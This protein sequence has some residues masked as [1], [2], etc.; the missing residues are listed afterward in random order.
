MNAEGPRVVFFDATSF[1][2]ASLTDT[3]LTIAEEG[4]YTPAWSDRV[5]GEAQ[6]A[7]L[8]ERPGQPPER[9]DRRFQAMRSGFPNATVLDEAE[10]GRLE[11]VMRN[12]PGDR[13]VLA[14][15]VVAEA[16]VLVTENVRHFPLAA[17][18]PHGIRVMKADDFLTAELQRGPDAIFAALT[19]QSARYTRPKRSVDE[20]LR[21]NLAPSVPTFTAAAQQQ[22][23]E[24]AVA[25]EPAQRSPS[26]ELR[27]VRDEFDPG[28]QPNRDVDRGDGYER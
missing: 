23:V 12:H 1:F 8:R 2:S 18:Q 16:Q 11:P 24:R 19:A 9:I 10:I 26:A 21:L 25:L 3:L 17:C 14:A 5:L 20:L 4:V 6:H 27:E 15:A 22:L 28:R 13:H 7:V